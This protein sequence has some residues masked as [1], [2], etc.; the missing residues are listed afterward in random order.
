[1]IEFIRSFRPGRG[2]HLIEKYAICQPLCPDCRA[3]LPDSGGQFLPDSAE[4]GRPSSSHNSSGTEAGPGK[5]V[6]VKGSGTRP[7]A[8]STSALRSQALR[9]LK[10][11]EARSDSRACGG[12]SPR[13]ATPPH[14]D[15]IADLIA[16]V[17]KEYQAGLANYQAGKID[18]AK[19][20]FDNAFN[21]LLDSKL[22]VRSDDRLEKEF[23]HI[24]AGVNQLNL[25]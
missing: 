20:N 4:A 18:A 17:E 11:P 8:R 21:A 23:E 25:G 14:T 7:S 12:R 9:P 2:T 3:R 15:A 16:R 24:V 19:K 22:D 10:P 6:N 1:M 5:S 13:K